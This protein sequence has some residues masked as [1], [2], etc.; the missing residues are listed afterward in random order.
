MYSSGVPANVSSAAIPSGSYW[1]VSASRNCNVSSPS[2][3]AHKS[4]YCQSQACYTN[5]HAA[6]WLAQNNF[7]D[8]APPPCRVV[9]NVLHSRYDLQSVDPEHQ[10]GHGKIGWRGRRPGLKGRV[11]ASDQR[12]PRALSRLEWTPLPMTVLAFHMSHAEMSCPARQPL[13]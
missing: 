4:K 8:L 10:A 2:T 1:R 9:S 7:I 5:G 6:A 3:S 11:G 12:L 13:C